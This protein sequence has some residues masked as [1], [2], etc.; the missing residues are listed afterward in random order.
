[1]SN[2]EKVLI[3][4]IANAVAPNLPLNVF[5]HLIAELIEFGTIQANLAEYAL[6]Y[7]EQVTEGEDME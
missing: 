3:E 5:D 4:V 1:M 6:N 2:P 7:Y